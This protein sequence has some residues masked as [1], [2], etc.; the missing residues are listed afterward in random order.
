MVSFQTPTVPKRTPVTAGW[1]RSSFS[2]PHNCSLNL[3]A[4]SSGE[5]LRLLADSESLVES[6]VALEGCL[7]TA[8]CRRP[9]SAAGS[10]VRPSEPAELHR[11]PPPIAGDLPLDPSGTL[12]RRSANGATISPRFGT[13]PTCGIRH[14]LDVL[15]FMVLR[16]QCDH[17]RGMVATSLA[18][19][20]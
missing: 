17:P 14:K 9:P 19:P 16:L 7:L 8:R 2:L 12:E 13:R 4:A 18:V 10:R 3:G 20:G 6:Q 15:S 1:R 11:A 5:S